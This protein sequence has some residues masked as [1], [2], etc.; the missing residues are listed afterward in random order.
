MGICRERGCK[1]P[2]FLCCICVYTVYMASGSTFIFTAPEVS[3]DA[4]GTMTNF[5]L[6]LP[7]LMIDFV[8]SGNNFALLL[9]VVVLGMLSGCVYWFRSRLFLEYAVR[10]D[11]ALLGSGKLDDGMDEVSLGSI[12]SV[13]MERASHFSY[14]GKPL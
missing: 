11:R 12:D 5:A 9:I 3:S 10:H 14:D 13:E 1:K 8:T 7:Q 4:V 2:L 6:A